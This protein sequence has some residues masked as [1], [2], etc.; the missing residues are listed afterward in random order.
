MQTSPL[1]TAS[2]PSSS[3]HA[4]DSQRH[5]FH[6]SWGADLL[7]HG[8]CRFRLWAPGQQALALRIG[9]R[10][11]PMNKTQDGWFEIVLS[12]VE[13]CSAYSFVLD[14]GMVVPDPAARA[15]AADQHGPSS[16][17][18]P[19]A[20]RW[21]S[22]DWVGRPWH[23]TVLYELHIGTFTP[24]G[25]FA[26]A[27]ERLSDLAQL[28]ITTIEI[29]PVGHFPG[30]R[31]WGYDGVY[32]YA[33]HR[34]YGTPD[35]L[36]AFVD[37]AH[38]LGLNV[39]L[40]VVYNHFGP[41]GNY[42]SAYAPEFF[43]QDR[44]TPWGASI[45]YR[46]APV[47]EF[48][49]QNALYWLEEFRLDGL[50]LDAIDHIVDDESD[51]HL[52][53]ELARRVRAAFPDRRIHLTT[54]DVR[55]ITALHERDGEG[56]ALLYDG[57]WNDD[58]HHVAH[59][60]AT[61]EDRGYYANYVEGIWRK[62]ARS[63]A[64]GYVY[65]GET[66]P[67]G[68]GK[69]VGERSAHL[70]PVAFVNFIQN[71]DQIGNRAF[72]ERLTALTDTATVELLTALLLLS[73][74]IPLLYMGEEYGETAPFYFFSDL[75]GKLGES[76]RNGRHEE[77]ERFGGFADGKTADDIPDPLSVETRHQST[78]DWDRR[79][80]M[81]GRA[82][83]DFVRELL[84]LRRRHVIPLLPRAGAYSGQVLAADDGLVA[85]DWMLGEKR[86]ELRLNFSQDRRPI[87]AVRGDILFSWPLRT[88]E[89]LRKEGELLP[90]SI[91]F[92]L[93]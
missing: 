6:K 29:M 60:I 59:V 56:R 22:S 79:E 36:K 35:D 51:V 15:Q 32:L 64:E 73:P 3:S 76:V 74:Q 19:H 82:R 4:H 43:V 61:G 5:R 1:S 67:S 45:D 65:Q 20:Y 62:L 37:T 93:G 69:P 41:D 66:Q 14:D 27:A 26:A 13:P 39:I 49:I 54:E 23:E 25:T 85:I 17:V 50:R 75:D 44:A 89:S 38:R 78:L 12:D 9:G 34:D 47:R 24:Q 81:D 8:A 68:D 46:Q 84:A 55:N 80:R 71:H 58:F 7:D 63:L 33:P 21:H 52:L 53:V 90:S 40:D 2:A 72:G 92:A 48:F 87:P 28:G 30:D 10:D 88:H 91:A 57:E 86:L 18:D 16:V 77:A 31:N 70:P 42:I 11:H 83:L